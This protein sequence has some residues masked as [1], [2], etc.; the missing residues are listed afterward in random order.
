MGRGF[1]YIKLSVSLLSDRA[2]H[3]AAASLWE[4]KRNQKCADP[5]GSALVITCVDGFLI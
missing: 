4:R 2:L 3:Q 1:V 5:N